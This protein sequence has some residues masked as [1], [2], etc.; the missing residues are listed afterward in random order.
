ML[1]TPPPPASDFPN[2]IRNSPRSEPFI[3]LWCH[4]RPL[5]CSCVLRHRGLA[6]TVVTNIVTIP[7]AVTFMLRRC[8]LMKNSWHPWIWSPGS[9]WARTNQLCFLSG[10]S[11]CVFSKK[12]PINN[13]AMPWCIVAAVIGHFKASNSP[14]HSKTVIIWLRGGIRLR[15]GSIQKTNPNSC[16]LIIMPRNLFAP[17]RKAAGSFFTSRREFFT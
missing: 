3:L 8:P 14:P 11:E 7:V 2:K 9:E 4:S 1:V 5:C 13:A 6:P 15:G 10:V 12:C 16:F 17:P